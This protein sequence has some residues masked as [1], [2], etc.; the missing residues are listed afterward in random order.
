MSETQPLLQKSKS[1]AQNAVSEQDKQKLAEIVGAFRAGKLPSQEQTTAALQKLLRSDVLARGSIGRTG[2]LSDKGIKVVDDFKQV[3]EMIIQVGMAKN[4]E[5]TWAS[6]SLLTCIDDD[7]IQKFLYHTSQ[8]DVSVDADV[9]GVGNVSIPELK[10]DGTQ[11]AQSLQTI[12]SLFISSA[13]FRD[14]INGVL[15]VMRDIFADSAELV[16][17]TA[18]D[19]ADKSR[20]QD[21]DISNAKGKGKQLQQSVQSGKLQGSAKET[22]SKV[23][24]YIDEKTPDDAKDEMNEKLK[25]IVVEVQSNSA[26]QDSV[27]SIIEIVQKYAGKAQEAAEQAAD[28]VDV[29]AD[30][31]SKKAITE[32]R[33]IV[34][35]FTNKPLDDLISAIQKVASH[36]QDNEDVKSYFNDLTSFLD[37]ALHDEGYVMTTKASRKVDKL[38]ERAQDLLKTNS[39]WKRDAQ[40]LLYQ[41]ETYVK[42][43]RDDKITTNLARAIQTFGEDLADLMKNLTHFASGGDNIAKDFFNVVVPRIISQIQYIPCPRIEYKSADLDVAIDHLVF[44][45]ASFIP[46]HAHIDNR[47]NLSFYQGYAAFVS[48]FNS[49]LKVHVDGLRMSARDISFY[50]FK[51]TGFQWEDSGLLDVSFKKGISFDILLDQASE[52]DR[53]TFFKVRKVKV[54]V[55]GLSFNL[56]ETQHSI[57]NFIAKPLIRPLVESSLSSALEGAIE[58]YLQ[59]ADLELFALQQRV[60]AVTRAKPTPAAYVRALLSSGGSSKGKV[61]TTNRGIIKTGRR[62]DYVL[63]I[64]VD[65]QLLPGKGGPKGYKERKELIH[66]GKKQ[67]QKLVGGAKNAAKDAA[68]TAK[69]AANNI[70]QQAGDLKAQS[71]AAKSKAEDDD[72]WR[73]EAFSL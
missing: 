39:E 28:K 5:S 42:A 72:G 54:N 53:E 45:S 63:A 13:E 18:Q 30:D 57:A 11:A 9:S 29:Q 67:A 40:A 47:N 3:I 1:T 49:T 68:S 43:I 59:K 10:E 60:M 56:R 70:K 35:A 7:K 37:R 4:G 61:K 26:Y 55:S 51:K 20:E 33:A 52:S 69:G 27:D 73:S 23:R 44:E 16:A 14:L 31:D 2:R 12:G 21:I 46:D 50:V 32:L 15:E 36:V 19:A 34:E 65:E 8:A 62:G 24:T 17:K 38:Y 25:K 6:F 64:G 48:E 22:F 58:D 41:F 66:D 71:D